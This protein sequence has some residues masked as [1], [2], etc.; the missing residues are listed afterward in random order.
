MPYFKCPNKYRETVDHFRHAFTGRE[1]DKFGNLRKWWKNSSI[2]KFNN[3][4]QCIVE[5]YSQYELG[6]EKVRLAHIANMLIEWMN[7]IWHD[8]MQGM[9]PYTWL[10][11]IRNIPL[12]PLH[13]RPV[14][15]SGDPIRKYYRNLMICYHECRFCILDTF[16]YHYSFIW[17]ILVW[18]DNVS[19]NDSL[20]ETWVRTPNMHSWLP[21]LLCLR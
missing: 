11:A 10:G 21:Y 18:N 16:I 9:L 7:N 20:P 1:Y 5:Q 14:M 8:K 3:R 2:E 15:D 17:L 19:G 13:L 4:S 6:G 12:S